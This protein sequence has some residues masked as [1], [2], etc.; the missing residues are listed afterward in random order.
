MLAYVICMHVK[1]T[2]PSHQVLLW[3]GR[4]NISISVCM[5]VYVFCNSTVVW[6]HK[7]PRLS[8]FSYSAAFA[9]M[10]NL[11]VGPFVSRDLL[12]DVSQLTKHIRVKSH[13]VKRTTSIG[14]RHTCMEARARG[15]KITSAVLKVLES[16][17]GPPLFWNVRSVEELGLF[18]EMSHQNWANGWRV[19]VRVVIKNSTVTLTELQKV[20]HPAAPL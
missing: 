8:A 12:W 3:A 16:T 15:R 1:L 5:C 10:W 2:P 4:F 17:G 11:A 14:P 7:I 9:I 13:E 20:N 6:L 19:L 18:P